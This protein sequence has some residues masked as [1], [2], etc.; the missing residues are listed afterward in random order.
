LLF[1]GRQTASDGT[2]GKEHFLIARILVVYGTTTG[3]TSRVARVIG[4][5]LRARNFEVDV[6][7][8]GM[9]GKAEDYI[10]VVV[11][12]S[13]RGGKYPRTVRHWVRANADALQ[14]RPT[15]FV[16]VCLAVLDRRP[17][18]RREL[19]AVVDRFL[20]ESGWEPSV[21]KLVAGALF[22]TQYNW[23]MRLVMKRIVKGAGGDTDTSRDY[24][25]TDWDDL[26]GFAQLFGDRVSRFLMPDQISLVA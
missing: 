20:R 10:G 18:A 13:V 23:F 4:D 19:Y 2:S 8:A 15:A 22:Y 14:Q 26:R 5:A 11:A 9:A 3:H 17:T 1:S 21:T 7:E 25:Y 24:E 16:S 12:A 6:A